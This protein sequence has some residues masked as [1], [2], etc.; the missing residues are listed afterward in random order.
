MASTRSICQPRGL[1][2]LLGDRHAGLPCSRVCTPGPPL[3]DLFDPDVVAPLVHEVVVVAKHSVGRSPKSARRTCG[4][5]MASWQGHRR[6]SRVPAR[7]GRE[8][9]RPGP[10]GSS[11]PW[12]HRRLCAGGTEPSGRGTGSAVQERVPV[13]RPAREPH[14]EPGRLGS[15]QA[16]APALPPSR[17]SAKRWREAPRI[18]ASPR[19]VVGPAAPHR[20]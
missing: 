17:L 10:S 8:L 5:S 18:G 19:R 1:R 15:G 20:G 13:S 16:G 14:P 4:P 7:E 9:T 2:S 3:E 6:G 12:T 11:G